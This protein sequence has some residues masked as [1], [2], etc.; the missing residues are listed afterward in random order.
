MKSKDLNVIIDVVNEI[1]E[2]S[3]FDVKMLENTT[4]QNKEGNNPISNF[5]FSIRPIV[6]KNIYE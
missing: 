1:T 6:T 3:T 5:L 4:E 2:Y